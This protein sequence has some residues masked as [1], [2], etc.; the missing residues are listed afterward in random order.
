MG[1]D[2]Q[3]IRLAAWQ[4]GTSMMLV[5]G[6]FVIAA[7][8]LGQTSTVG[9]TWPVAEPDALTE[10]EARVAQQPQTMAA[11]FGPREKWTAMQSAALGVAKADRKR[12]VVPFHTLDFDIRL[13]DGKLLYPKGFTFNPLEYVS[14]P[15]RLLVVHPDD[16]DWA[17]SRA[18]PSDWILLAGGQA[19]STDPVTMGETVGR[20]LFILEQR[21]K[22]RLGLTVAPVIVT[23]AGHKLELSEF[24][25]EP[26]P[27]ASRTTN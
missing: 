7:S 13:P 6:A 26:R 2:P 8:A 19:V 25:V 11:K 18:R 23:Q 12:T 9:R 22:E 4:F 14:L 16:L 24:A 17:I 27:P 5:L 21:V 15:Q 10:I 3:R 20:P 1:H